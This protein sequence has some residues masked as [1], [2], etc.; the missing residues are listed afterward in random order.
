MKSLKRT[1]ILATILAMLACLLCSC[2]VKVTYEATEGGL[3]IGQSSQSV[4]KSDG[5]ATFDAV[6]AKPNDGYR[7]VAWDDGLESPTRTDT[8]SKSG[9]FTAIFEKIP[10]I[11]IT[12]TA[13]DGGMIKG[14]EVQNLLQGDTTTQVEA[15]PYEGYEFIGWD[16]G[17][18]ST[19]RT[20]I[21]YVNETKKYLEGLI[22]QSYGK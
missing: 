9:S 22:E 1:L 7:F 18:E 10:I 2:S 21:A 20:D 8:L 16:D 12:Y 11:K 3:I 4:K 13:L 17:L 19:T 5:S 14:T 6:M 15:I